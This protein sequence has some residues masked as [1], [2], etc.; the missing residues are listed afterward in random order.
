MQRIVEFEWR[1]GLLAAVMGAAVAVAIALG[2][3]A[4]PAPPAVAPASAPPADFSGERALSHLREIAARPHPSGTRANFEVGN[5]IIRQLEAGGLKPELQETSFVTQNRSKDY[6]VVQVRNIMARV[7]GGAGQRGDALLLS[8]HYDS[9]P[10][11]PGASDDGAGVAVLLE[12]LRALLAGGRPT[13]DVIFLFTDAEE[14]GTYGAKAFVGQHP[15]SKDV[16]VALNFEARGTHGPAVMFETG[17]EDGWLVHEFMHAAPDPYANSLAAV[18][19]RYMAYGT[20]FS[21]MQQAGMSGLNFAFVEGLESYHTGRDTV[22]SLDPRSLQHQGETALALTRRL[23]TGDLT[24]R[25]RF[26]GTYFNLFRSLYVFYPTSWAGVLSVLV[27]VMY[28]AALYLARR[29][30]LLSW[31]GAPTAAGAL[32]VAIVFTTLT[33]GGI[34]VTVSGGG[35]PG[36]LL[37][38]GGYVYAALLLYSAAVFLITLR[39]C[40]RRVNMI[41]V[42]LG[43]LSLWMVGLIW[44]TLF[45]PTAAYLFQWPGLLACALALAA[46][47]RGRGEVRTT[48][49]IAGAA[50]SAVAVC[51]LLVPHIDSLHVALPLPFWGGICLVVVLALALLIPQLDLIARSVR[52]RAPAAGLAV[53]VA[54]GVLAGLTRYDAQHP[55]P[56]QVFYIADADAGT[57]TWVTRGEEPDAWTRQFFTSPRVAQPLREYLPDWYTGDTRGVNRVM[58]NS[59]PFVVSEP[60]VASVAADET[61]EGVRRVRLQINS[62]RNAPALNVRIHSEEGLSE[63]AVGEQKP[64]VWPAASTQPKAAG[65]A[66]AQPNALVGP[67]G[68]QDIVYVYYGF[69]ASGATLTVTTKAG[70]RIKVDIVERLYELPTTPDRQPSQ[71][72][73]E[74]FQARSYYDATMVRRSYTF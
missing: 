73:P 42:F 47:L 32:L 31:W 43:A 49:L 72:P 74:L 8:A 17:D 35:G 16:R 60:P 66:A 41:S 40:R 65:D 59:A 9:A 34:L 44:I 12:S 48:Y 3:A 7:E 24:N 22:E 70:A 67:Q 52:W 15:W 64:D 18:L 20:D 23:G 46:I 51:L 57:A 5:Y 61:A 28:A 27:L 53:A 36:P 4:R 38:A 71:R 30:R 10:G 19:Y 2:L 62:P 11:S 45:A 68:R 37:Y 21:V 39:V 58:T 26:T 33:A 14:L 6:V 55:Q 29:R 63:T 56:N 69:P 54:C 13:R 1:E 50:A 25:P